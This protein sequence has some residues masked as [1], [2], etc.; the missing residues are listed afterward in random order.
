MRNS[1]RLLSVMAAALSMFGCDSTTSSPTP[2]PSSQGP[3]KPAVANAGTA[4]AQAYE[5]MFR[6]E[7]MDPANPLGAD[8]QSLKSANV[9][10]RQAYAEN[11][12][13][14][15]AAFALA[16]TSLSLK[17]ND[18]AG[19]MDRAQANGLQIGGS[20][21]TLGTTS[22][23]VANDLPVLARAVADPAK[24]PVVHELQDTLES[25]LLPTMDEA[26]DLLSKAWADPSFEFRI[27]LD[28]V[29]FP[30]DTLILDRS[31]VGFAL[32]IL[33]A[34]RAQT[35]WLISYD[36]DIDQ[37]GEYSWIDTLG[38]W[39]IDAPAA[40]SPAQNAA[41]GKL[42]SLLA[43]GSS[44]LAV[45]PSKQALLASVPGEFLAALK[46]SREA[47]VLAYGLKQRSENRLETIMSIEDRDE[48]VRVVDS[49]IR[50]FSGPTTTNLYTR[51]TCKDTSWSVSSWNGTPNVYSHSSIFDRGSVLFF[52][53]GCGDYAYDYVSSTGEY[54]SHT[55][56]VELSSRSQQ[57]T[58]DLGKLVSLPDLKVFLPKYTW[59]ETADW[60]EHGPISFV[61]ATNARVLPESLDSIY[62]ASGFDAVKPLITW[63]DPTFGG[64]FPQLTTSG[65]V[66]ELFRLASEKET[67]SPTFAARGPIALY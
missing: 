3:A 11:P 48:F 55:R 47:A 63:E 4:A 21:N 61:S 17:L 12:T 27:A 38:N 29:E 36:F 64:V 7:E 67:V 57:V 24:A 62:D 10:L 15:R 65:A 30:E 6:Q 53:Q 1:L 9:S 25:L 54:E 5:A 66:M 52:E 26:F 42:K 41:L 40:I 13:D 33:Q 8:L 50:L 59:N 60:R 35:R 34:V 37:A 16:I 56:T 39:D 20:N 2:V 22:E 14:S 46:R 28:P 44:F 32:S 18:M 19:T 58:I 31:D 49:A 45:R 23:A 51:A 43:P